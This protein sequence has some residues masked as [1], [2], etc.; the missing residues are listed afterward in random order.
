MLVV[1]GLEPVDLK[2]D[3]GEIL[4][5]RRG[6][7]RHFGGPVGEALA[8]VEAG[9]GVGAGKHGRALLLLG[10]H[11]RFVLEIDVAAPAEQD[12]RDIEGQGGAGDRALR[13]RSPPAIRKC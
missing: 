12:Q 13:G 6:L 1:D 9:D 7:A 8:V 2:G 4:A 11:L 10:A 5:A 3:D